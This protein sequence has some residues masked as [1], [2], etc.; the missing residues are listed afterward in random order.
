MLTTERGRSI[1]RA[2]SSTNVTEAPVTEPVQ[3]SKL[4]RLGRGSEDLRQTALRNGFRSSSTEKP[5][6]NIPMA[7]HKVRPKW[8]HF[9]IAPE[10]KV[11]IKKASISPL[12]VIKPAASPSPPTAAV[13]NKFNDLAT[14][15][16][17]DTKTQEGFH[18]KEGLNLKESFSQGF[19]SLGALKGFSGFKSF[20]L[21]NEMSG[22]LAPNEPAVLPPTTNTYNLPSNSFG[23]TPSDTYKHKHKKQS[24][25]AYSSEL[26]S[27]DLEDLIELTEET[28]VADVIQEIHDFQTSLVS[29]S[30]PQKETGANRTQQKLLDLK[31][32][33]SNDRAPYTQLSNLLDYSVKIQHEAILAE[34]TQIRLRF[35]GYVSN[36]SET[37]IVCL[38]GVLG[39]IQRLR[40]QYIGGN[41]LVTQETKDEYLLNMWELELQSFAE[42]LTPVLA[43][44]SLPSLLSMSEPNREADEDIYKNRDIEMPLSISSMA[45]NVML[46]RETL[47]DA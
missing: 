2:R 25:S 22:F 15:D 16:L 40:G 6:K 29:R 47:T 7:E 11:E 23:A 33:M 35:S 5:N 42:P 34:W 14:H 41:L 3:R 12:T 46:S 36:K 24:H 44:T 39:F 4:T 17:V 21:T 19:K 32:L 28:T 26:D 13:D 9:T 18:A 27:D 37:D 45:R 38:A 30:S 20:G 31:D 43:L 8:S 1:L 10:R